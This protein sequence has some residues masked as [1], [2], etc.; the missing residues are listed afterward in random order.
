MA[1]RQ[2]PRIAH[3]GSL[4]K[5]LTRAAAKGAKFPVLSGVCGLGRAFC[6]PVVCLAQ[7]NR[8][9][10][11]VEGEHALVLAQADPERV[12]VG[13][14]PVSGV[15]DGVQAADGHTGVVGVDDLG[16]AFALDGQGASSILAHAYSVAPAGPV[17]DVDG[18]CLGGRL[19]SGE[20]SRDQ[21][22]QN[23]EGALVHGV[24]E[25]V[26]TTIARALVMNEAICSRD[27]T[28]SGPKVPWPVPRVTPSWAS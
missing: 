13:A 10:F 25:D 26:G 19:A 2:G 5:E 27:M 20:K 11:Y 18:I 15:E 1:A 16:G 22:N 17:E 4:Q 7:P 8:A 9:T 3:G 14:H 6:F 24:E 21:S 23:Y 28:P 12:G